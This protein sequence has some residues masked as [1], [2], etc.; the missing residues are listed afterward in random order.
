VAVRLLGSFPAWVS[1]A[2]SSSYALQLDV[3]VSEGRLRAT[4]TEQMLPGPTRDLYL[5]TR[6]T[7]WILFGAVGRSHS[8]TDIEMDF[9]E[10]CKTYKED[11]ACPSFDS[12]IFRSP[13]DCTWE[14]PWK[15]DQRCQQVPADSRA[16]QR[17]WY[18]NQNR[19]FDP[20][21][22]NRLQSESYPEL[23]YSPETTSWWVDPDM[24]PG[25]FKGSNA[26]GYE[27]AYDRL[28]VISAVSSVGFPIYNY[29][30][31]TNA[32]ERH[33][34]WSTYVAFESDGA[35]YG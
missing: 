11:E 10:E 12:D 19:D 15:G 26:S 33:T 9:V 24:M 13:C 3:F 4:Y 20:E 17:F 27:T 22:G 14:D 25:S 35:F 5:L 6:L 8:F 31:N 16:I 18:L 30:T 1:S 32:K 7:G 28:R 34:A 29:V 21:T 23:D 2:E